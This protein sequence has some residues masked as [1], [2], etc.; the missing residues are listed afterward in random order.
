MNWSKATMKQLLIILH[1][2][3]CPACYK[4]MALNEIQKRLGESR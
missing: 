2:E 1:F 3:D 4:Q